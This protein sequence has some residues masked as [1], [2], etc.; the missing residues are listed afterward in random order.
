MIRRLVVAVVA[1]G[2]AALPCAPAAASVPEPPRHVPAPVAAV[3]AG[4]DDFSFE[5]MTAAYRLDRDAQGYATLEVT[6]T[7]VAVFPETDQNRGIVRAIP[8]RDPDA[9]TDY[10]V[11]IR[12][13][14]DGDGNRVPYETDSDD[15]FLRLALGTDAYVHGRT[16]YVIRYAERN[17][18][19][20]FADTRSDEF[21][22]DVNGTGAAQPFG[23]VTADLSVAPELLPRMTGRA[24][25]YAGSQDATDTCP[26]T[27]T[28]DGWTATASTL[29]PHQTLTIAVGFRQGTFT[30]P[31]TPDDSP[32]AWLAP[33]VLL[34][35]TAAL[36]VAVIVARTRVWR[37]APGR[38]IVIPRYEPPE[39][40]GVLEASHF[41]D[42]AESGLP[43]LFVEFAVE[44]AAKLVE[45]PEKPADE[46]YAL[47]LIDPDRIAEEDDR[48]ALDE[49][50]GST[51]R[52]AGSVVVLDR[53]DAKLGDRLARTSGH[54]RA[55]LREEGIYVR[56][57]SALGSGLQITA[58]VLA[59]LGVLMVFA[60]AA[61]DV[62]TPVFWLVTVLS[63]AG[64]AVLIGFA[65]SPERLTEKGAELREHLLGMRDYLRL[66]EQDRLRVLQSSEGAE[67][68]R[69]DPADG[70]QVVKLYE[71]LLPWA[72]VW[73]LEDSWS[74][75]LGERY[76]TTP[77]TG[78]TVS[79]LNTGMLTN[80]GGFS[81][82]MALGAFATTPPASTSSWSGSS[83][84]S[85]SGGSFGGG[86]AGGGGGGG[87]FGGR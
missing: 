38:G 21:Y 23:T 44:G 48:R 12:S 1:L 71:R 27:R 41:L 35:L 15:G 40:I 78:S 3:P 17:V 36:A 29:G 37:D 70:A 22:W 57:R 34:G 28:D 14:E 49:V 56:R 6:E 18:V 39:G 52:T 62:G 65:R 66:A 54:A 46:R 2:L 24:A 10:D 43:A 83:G 79:Y 86:F 42:R 60:G 9:R 63:V 50:W 11:R 55:S 8:E 84:S 69:V 73:G 64:C 77:T 30:P 51:K 31:P 75:V 61:S 59:L 53:G 13:V 58:V 26:I 85:F 33:W 19:R 25:C 68:T 82:S 5:S 80:L 87:G 4:V 74:R 45:S 20:P 72:M 67:R 16:T 32:L 7:I 47:E 76:A 81:R